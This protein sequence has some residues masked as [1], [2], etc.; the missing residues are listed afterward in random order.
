MPAACRSLS[1]PPRNE[2]FLPA[3]N[4]KVKRSGQGGFLILP[5]AGSQLW[6]GICC[7]LDKLHG[8]KVHKRA[9]T[10]G[11]HFAQVRILEQ[12]QEPIATQPQATI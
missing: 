12:L 2:L 10:S 8:D 7:Q 1:V 4:S 5:L 6:I 11:G 3:G 9:D